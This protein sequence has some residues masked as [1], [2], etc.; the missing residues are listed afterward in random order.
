[1]FQIFEFSHKMTPVDFN[2]GFWRENSNFFKMKTFARCE[3]IW[4]I[5]KHNAIQAQ[6]KRF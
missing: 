6:I 5:F 1:M 3:T 4:D 2:V